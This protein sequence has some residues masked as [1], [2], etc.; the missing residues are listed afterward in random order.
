QGRGAAG[1]RR[2]GLASSLV[3]AQVALSLMLVVAAGL[4]VRTFASLETFDLGFERDRALVVT[5]NAQR[6]SI[7]PSDR[8][9]AFERVL[10]R[11]HAP[12]GVADAALSVITPVSGQGWNNS[13]DVSNAPTKTPLK[14]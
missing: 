9:P 4:F 10:H 12:R 6:T 5:I 7:D 2:A 1:G 3:V 11:V 14:C 13:V 8:F